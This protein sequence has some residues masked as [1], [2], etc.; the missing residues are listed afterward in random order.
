MSSDFFFQDTG[1]V[2]FDAA[3][4]EFEL[5]DSFESLSVGEMETNRIVSPIDKDLLIQSDAGLDLVITLMPYSH[6][7][8]SALKKALSWPI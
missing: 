6:R 8:K 7:L 1:K 4:P 2:I 5:S 3:S